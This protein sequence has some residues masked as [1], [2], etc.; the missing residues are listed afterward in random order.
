M[1]HNVIINIKNFYDQPIDFDV[2]RYKEIRKLTID[3]G[4]NCSAGRLPYYY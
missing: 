1:N 4:Q 2:K 3:H